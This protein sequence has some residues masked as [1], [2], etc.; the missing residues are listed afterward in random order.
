MRQ[1]SLACLLALLVSGCASIK[2]GHDPVVVNAERTTELALNVFD[3]FLAWEYMHH[4]QLT[5]V[6]EVGMAA[7]FIRANGQD[8]LI[9]ARTMTKTYKANRTEESKVNLDT[10]M[11]VLR[12]GI[13]EARKYLADQERLLALP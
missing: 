5:V 2:P 13:A 10:A 11:A 4:D 7:D 1:L 6:P 9:T 3:T 12:V 8:W